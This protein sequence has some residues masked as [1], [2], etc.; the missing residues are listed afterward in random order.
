LPSCAAT[1]AED[2]DEGEQGHAEAREAV[3]YELAVAFALKRTGREVSGEKE[4]EAHEVSLIGCDEES[5]QDARRFIGDMQFVVEP[6]ARGAVGN[7]SVVEEDE[8]GHERAEAVDVEVARR[9]GVG[10][11]GGRLSRCDRYGVSSF[12]HET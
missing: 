10:D 9:G 3:G 6:T 11:G 2:K 8:R 1:I 7:R 12:G 4:E 5:E